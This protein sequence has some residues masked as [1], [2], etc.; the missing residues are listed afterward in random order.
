MPLLRPDI[1]TVR[2]LLSEEGGGLVPHENAVFGAKCKGASTLIRRFWT[3]GRQLSAHT[4]C[5]CQCQCH[6][7]P[8]WDIGAEST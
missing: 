7:L 3:A 6:C 8:D 1:D 5:Q 4:Q 2:A